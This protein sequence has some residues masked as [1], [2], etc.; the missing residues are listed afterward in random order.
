MSN[1]SNFYSKSSNLTKLV[2]LFL[3]CSRYWA[4]SLTPTHSSSI[5]IS[6]SN[7]DIMVSV[8]SL[9]SISYSSIF[10][11]RSSVLLILRIYSSFIRLS[12][13]ISLIFVFVRCF[14]YILMSDPF[15]DTFFS[16]KSYFWQI[17]SILS[18]QR[19][20]V[21]PILRSNVFLVSESWFLILMISS[22]RT[23]F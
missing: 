6:T 8:L 19:F 14:W 3:C 23:L 1:Y 15:Y 9:N 13:V 7:L 21:S 12:N 11:T 16:A 2:I 17:W 4:N 5:L 22:G 18:L 10:W 20:C